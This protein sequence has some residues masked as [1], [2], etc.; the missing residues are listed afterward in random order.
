MEE[1]AH[2]V[3][4]GVVDLAVLLALVPLPLDR[5]PLFLHAHGRRSPNQ[6][7]PLAPNGGESNRM[8][9]AGVL[10]RLL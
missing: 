3:E 1:G 5:V 2:V 9:A 10:T 8:G 4:A 6:S 7:G